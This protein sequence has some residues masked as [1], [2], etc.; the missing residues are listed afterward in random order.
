MSSGRT[1]RPRESTPLSGCHQ[2]HQPNHPAGRDRTSMSCSNRLDL[3]PVLMTSSLQY[4]KPI[5][6]IMKS[7]LQNTRDR[8]GRYQRSRLKV[9]QEGDVV[10]SQ[11]QGRS[12]SDDVLV[13]RTPP[14][15]PSGIM[16]V[17]ST[18]P[19]FN[20]FIV[21][22]F[23]HLNVRDT[24]L[25]GLPPTTTPRRVLLD[26]G[27]DFNLISRGAYAQLNVDK[28]PYQGLVHS[29][30]GYSELESTVLLH[31]HF[32]VPDVSAGRPPRHCAP[33]HI[34]REDSD[35]KFD[36]IIGRQWIVENWTEFTAL[37]ESNSKAQAKA[38]VHGKCE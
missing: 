30:G 8:N 38:E 24:L 37:V 17:N 13:K 21:L 3:E 32:R 18:R 26:T 16:S 33:F 15:R 19:Q 12:S 29:I 22:M 7:P 9:L 23:I 10:I 2:V 35:P 25:G 6:K 20:P 1:S 5:S 34:L 27:A 11:E 31:W 4:A 28:E 36:C 14:S